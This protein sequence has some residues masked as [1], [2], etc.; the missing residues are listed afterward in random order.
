[1]S[2][3]MA[4]RSP[5]RHRRSCNAKCY[6]AK[7]PECD[8]MCGGR[9]HGVGELQAHRNSRETGVS[10]IARAIRIPSVKKRRGLVPQQRDLFS[11]LDDE[12]NG[13]A[14]KSEAHNER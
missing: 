7:R 13:A 14:V 8:C 12:A 11:A 9:N 1:M 5:G 3:L 6:N 4:S 2:T 10:W